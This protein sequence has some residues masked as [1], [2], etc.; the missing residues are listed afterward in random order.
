MSAS[1]D[2][3]EIRLLDSWSVVSA[4][5]P[6][7]GPS[8]RISFPYRLRYVSAVMSASG[9]RSEISLPCSERCLSAVMSASGD[10]SEI[11][12]FV[13]LSHDRLT[14]CSIP[15]SCRT[16]L[17]VPSDRKA[18]ISPRVIGA[19]AA[20]SS[21]SSTALRRAVSGMSTSVSESSASPALGRENAGS[22]ATGALETP[23]NKAQAASAM[24]APRLAARQPLPTRFAIA[25]SPL[26][27]G[28]KFA[29]RWRFRS[30]VRTASAG[31]WRPRALENLLTPS[32]RPP[33]P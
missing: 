8:S 12:P 31:P 21:A 11:A 22:A 13:E 24:E 19:P 1:G 9:D 18:A 2:T 5:M 30:R 15:V 32:T 10:R 23:A 4:V 3:S 28:R 29:T 7:S 20:L 14:A 17:P 16:P 25:H 26:R 33:G 6:A 27:L